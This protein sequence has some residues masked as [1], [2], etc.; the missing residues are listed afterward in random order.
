MSYIRETAVAYLV[1][2]DSETEAAKIS[3]RILSPSIQ[4][5]RPLALRVLDQDREEKETVITLP[6]KAARLLLDILVL[7]AEGK[8]V[9]II[10][11]H[12]ELTTQQAA[13]LLNMSRPSFVQ[14]VENGEIPFRKV[15]THRRVLLS[16]VMT[17]KERTD[18]ARK[19]NLD[20]LAALGQELGLGY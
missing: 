4:R 8:A 7:M 20:E 17:Y 12:A 10:P 11:T 3:S 2:S 16:D 5:D 6:A 18:E 1:P 15:G 9:T 14:L 19:K 13:D